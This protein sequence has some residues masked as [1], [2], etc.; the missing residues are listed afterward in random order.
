MQVMSM[1]GTARRKKGPQSC[2]HWLDQPRSRDPPAERRSTLRP[3]PAHCPAHLPAHCLR[4]GHLASCGG[5]PAAPAPEGAGEG[6]RGLEGAGGGRRGRRMP[7]QRPWRFG[8]RACDTRGSWVTAPSFL[9]PVPSYENFSPYLLLP[10]SVAGRTAR[11][12]GAKRFCEAGRAVQ[13]R[14]TRPESC[15]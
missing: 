8:L 4:P 7:G 2:R 12:Q 13:P 10:G 14:G 6:W 5:W 3:R 9:D 1:L 11:H 15:S